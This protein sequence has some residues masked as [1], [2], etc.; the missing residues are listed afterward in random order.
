MKTVKASLF[1][2]QG[3]LSVLFI[4]TVF[5]AVEGHAN[6]FLLL[7]TYHN[8]FAD[9]VFYY[10]TYIGDGWFAVIVAA[11]LMMFSKTR[12]LGILVFASYAASG[13]LAQL[14]KHIAETPRPSAYFTF[15]QYHK[16]VEGVHLA[17]SNSFP[18]GHTTTAFSLATLLACYTQNKKTQFI[19]LLLAIGTGYSRIYL[20]Q[21]FLTDVLMGA[22]LGALTSIITIGIA[23]KNNQ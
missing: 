16:F 12:K 3:L 23:E 2:F 13:I 20:G 17:G 19:Y 11:A 9:F 15:Q 22:F 14:V 6:S 8:P 21:H 18:S 7:N 10:T 5:L 4:A 1:Y